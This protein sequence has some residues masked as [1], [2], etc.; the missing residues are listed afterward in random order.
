M[1][2]V[3]DNK[4]IEKLEDIAYLKRLKQALFKVENIY[5]EFTTSFYEGD[6][7]Q[8]ITHRA[9]RVFA[10][11]LYHQ[12]RTLMEN[13]KEENYYLNGEIW[14]DSKIANVESSYSCYPDLVLHGSL[15]CIEDGK[16]FF[17]C[18]IKMGSNPNLLNDLRKLTNLSKSE[19]NFQFYIFLC[20]GMTKKKLSDKIQKKKQCLKEKYNGNIVCICKGKGKHVEMFR[21]KEILSQNQIRNNDMS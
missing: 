10:Y 21:L 8:T 13:E 15:G 6:E 3:V 17:L 16:Q 12:F 20:V 18:E 19:L 9:E 4:N 7:L 14:K 11:E 5:M 1:C 2:N